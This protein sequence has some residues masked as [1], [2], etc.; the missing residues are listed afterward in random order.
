MKATAYEHSAQLPI[1]SPSGTVAARM[2]TVAGTTEPKP[3]PPPRQKPWPLARIAG[4][5]QF[6][7]RRQ[8]AGG[9]AALERAE[10]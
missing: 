2:P 4:G 10:E 3:R 8:H 5:E 7:K 1:A 6:G 9:E